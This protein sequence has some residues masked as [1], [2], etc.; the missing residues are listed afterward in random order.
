MPDCSA[1]C[2]GV[3]RS[4]YGRHLLDHLAAHGAGL[5][6]GQVAVVAVLQIHA[7]LGSGLHLEL[8]HGLLGLGN[9]KLVIVAAHLNSLFM[10]VFRERIPVFGENRLFLS[11]GIACVVFHHKFPAFSGKTGEEWKQNKGL[12][13]V[14]NKTLLS[15]LLRQR[16]TIVPASLSRLFAPLLQFEKWEIHT[17][18]LHFSNFELGQ[19]SWLSLL[20]K[21]C[22]VALKTR[23]NRLRLGS[24]QGSGTG[25]SYKSM[26][27][28]DEI[29]VGFPNSGYCFCDN[30]QY[31]SL[32]SRPK[33][34]T[35]EICGK[36]RKK[37][38]V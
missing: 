29:S 19:K 25:I 34:K 13:R 32:K 16:R 9:V 3:V 6:G 1:V 18:F 37:L 21:L 22:G 10:V 12:I 8:L 5:P 35:G 4:S 11:A 17:V 27:R 20:V 28:K 30:S 33:R 36:N 31:I 23:I 26:R 7:D 24:S 14:F 15:V 38:D 2:T